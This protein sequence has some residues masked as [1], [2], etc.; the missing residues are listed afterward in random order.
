[1]VVNLEGR[2]PSASVIYDLVVR[3]G[4]EVASRKHGEMSLVLATPDPA[5]ANVIRAL[6]EANDVSLFLAQ[7]V[8]EVGS[9][10]PVGRLTAADLETLR[11]LKELGG[12]AS[13][14]NLAKAASIDH[15]AAGNRLAVLD[16]KQLVLRVDRPRRQGN[17]YLDPRIASAAARDEP[18]DPL[19]P[20]ASTPSG[21]RIDA[22]ALASLQRTEK[23]KAVAEG[24]REFLE[25]HA[26]EM[27][28]QH[29][30][31]AKVM[32]AGDKPPIKT[33][34][35]RQVKSGVRSRSKRAEHR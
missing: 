35:T 34:A 8:L 20:H 33:Y 6:A 11:V 26:D 2:F 24:W 30:E 23:P 15:T 32:R 5:L 19:S 31:A 29:A 28:R 7:S 16:K 1:M 12:R 25:K 22:R 13:V 4:K 10:E 14:G 21:V 18:F 3:L 27:A 9:A 17:V